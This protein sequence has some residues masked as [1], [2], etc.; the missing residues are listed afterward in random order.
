MGTPRR[1]K[2]SRIGVNALVQ[3]SFRSCAKEP[4]KETDPG[5]CG[6]HTMSPIA[7]AVFLRWS[8]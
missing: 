4:A 6:N 7:E 8:T 2:K 3:R 1:M 5:V